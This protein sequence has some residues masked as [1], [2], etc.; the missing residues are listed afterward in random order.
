MANL[1][2]LWLLGQLS[3]GMCGTIRRHSPEPSFNT[4]LFL[5]S[6]G[7][8]YKRGWLRFH[9]TWRPEAQSFDLSSVLCHKHSR[10][11]YLLG[12]N[13]VGNEVGGGGSRERLIITADTREKNRV[14]LRGGEWKHHSVRF[15]VLPTQRKNTGIS[16][17]L[18]WDKK[19]TVYWYII[20]V[21]FSSSQRFLVYRVISKD[22]LV[23]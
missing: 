14:G 6:T 22:S 15:G 20:N 1:E 18:L 17:I 10:Y 23:S 9:L 12:T 7:S 21:S 19:V 2:L 11:S 16:T 4:V 13:S 5:Y 3:A 8:I